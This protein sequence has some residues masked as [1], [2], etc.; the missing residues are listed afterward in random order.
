MARAP[1]R[2]TAGRDERR[3]VH[4]LLGF[5][6]C[7]TVP[8]VVAVAVIGLVEDDLAPARG[9][10]SDA[11]YRVARVSV[12]AFDLAPGQRSG[13]DLAVIFTGGQLRVDGGCVTT[14]ADYTLD[15]SG[16]LTLSGHRLLGQRRSC[17][18]DLVAGLLLRTVETGARVRIDADRPELRRIEREGIAISLVHVVTN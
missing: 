16:T 2:A 10:Q 18:G 14:E 9:S 11:V 4:S 7:L 13:S 3:G 15:S 6:L 1:S 8:G 5:S 12:G 17:A